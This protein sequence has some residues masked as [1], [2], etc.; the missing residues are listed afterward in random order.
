M[1]AAVIKATLLGLSTGVLCL[2]YCAPAL[3]PIIMGH[4]Q[5]R[6]LDR[7]RPLLWF[8]LGRF[9]AYATTGLLAGLAGRFVVTPVSNTLIGMV[10]IAIAI[11]LLLYSLMQKLPGLSLCHYFYSSRGGQMGYFALGLLLGFNLC[12]PFLAALADVLVAGSVMYGILFF[13]TF[14]VITSL[15][16]LPLLLITA[17]S[18]KPEIRQI[19]RM[20]AFMSG[21][22]Y[23]LMGILRLL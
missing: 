10:Y 18:I 22:V 6:W 1:W 17:I 23:G 9:L 2:G 19:G 15:F 13:L 20:A 14:F 8:V 5:W 3:A 4:A 12:P 21:V 16:F 11:L 7:V